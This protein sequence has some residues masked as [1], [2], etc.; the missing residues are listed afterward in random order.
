MSTAKRFQKALLLVGLFGFAM[1]FSLAAYGFLL[2]KEREARVAFSSI[3][4]GVNLFWEM[5]FLYGVLGVLFFLCVVLSKWKSGLKFIILI[6]LFFLMTIYELKLISASGIVSPIWP[7][8]E[9][10]NF[11]FDK[12]AFF[13]LFWSTLEF[14]LNLTVWRLTRAHK[15]LP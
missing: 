9:F 4:P 14:V 1:S 2:A 7:E 13:L 12:G 8:Y 15:D 10:C 3:N 11:L 5:A 6:P